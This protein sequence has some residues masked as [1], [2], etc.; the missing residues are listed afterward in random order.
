MS[1]K[2]TF[3]ELVEK[4]S[5]KT[6]QSEQLTDDFIHQ[7][8]GII[9]SSLGEGEKISISGFGKFELRWR[10]ERKGRNPQTGEELTIPGQNKAV[11]KP[12]KALREH[13]NEPFKNLENQVIGD[14]RK[15]DRKAGIVPALP[16]PATTTTPSASQKK[17]PKVK[18]KNAESIDD[19]IMERESPVDEIIPP[20]QTESKITEQ[21]KPASQ[22]ENDLSFVSNTEKQNRKTLANDVQKNEKFRWS[23]AAISIVV[24]VAAFMIIFVIF[25]SN[26]TTESDNSS[27]TEQTGLTQIDGRQV[28]GENDTAAQ[29]DEHNNNETDAEEPSVGEQSHSITQGESLWNIAQNQ[30][31]DPYLWPIIYSENSGEIQNPNEI[32]PGVTL[33]IPVLNDPQNLSGDER[34]RVALGYISVYDWIVENQPENARYY[35]WA[36]GSFSQEVLRDASDRVKEDDLEFATQR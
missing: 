36:A 17:P 31:N 2:I 35:L 18:P 6:N 25:Q 27:I 24:L 22:P 32:L 7:L 4:I 26:Q 5:A 12:F 33:Q 34:E 29:T 8:A 16:F 30:Y 10:D 14:N 19:L 1:E 11:F 28:S 23:Y 20:V 21:P 3:K 9:E 13:V 15:E